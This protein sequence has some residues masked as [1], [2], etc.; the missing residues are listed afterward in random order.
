MKK[1]SGHRRRTKIL[2]RSRK[3]LRR[4]IKR[5]RLGKG[6]RRPTRRY[7]RVQRGGLGGEEST[8]ISP[9]DCV[10]IDDFKNFYFAAVNSFYTEIGRPKE[11]TFYSTDDHK[12][13]FDDWMKGANT[14]KVHDSIYSSN[15]PYPLSIIDNILKQILDQKKKLC[16][17]SIYTIN[18]RIKG[19][20]GIEDKLKKLSQSI[21]TP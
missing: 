9:P 4:T 8:G 14:V 5:K 16:E 6:R 1:K 11:G 19:H 13:K 21:Q 15:Y 3:N 7:S 17:E 12:K 2:R 10:T 20:T 18:Q